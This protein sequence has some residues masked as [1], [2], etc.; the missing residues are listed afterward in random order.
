MQPIVPADAHHLSIS[1][2][3]LWMGYHNCFIPSAVL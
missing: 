1:T 3:A 2:V